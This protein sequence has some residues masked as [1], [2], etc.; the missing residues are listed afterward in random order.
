MALSRLPTP[1]SAS[2]SAPA[3]GR[4]GGLLCLF[5]TG[6]GVG[7]ANGLGAIR[8][9]G[10]INNNGSSGVQLAFN[11]LVGGNVFDLFHLHGG[12]PDSLDRHAGSRQFSCGSPRRAHR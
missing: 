7:V 9:D 1:V 2:R 12:W 4:I 10:E 5:N 6:G 11:T 3:I 8:L